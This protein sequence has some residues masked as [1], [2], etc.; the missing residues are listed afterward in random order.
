MNFPV[1]LAPRRRQGLP[2]D[3][4]ARVLRGSGQRRLRPGA[5]VADRLRAELQAAQGLRLSFVV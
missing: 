4:A 3:G 5:V 1:Q 2:G